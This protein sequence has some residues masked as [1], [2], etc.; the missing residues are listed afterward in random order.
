MAPPDWPEDDP[1]D[2]ECEPGDESL[3]RFAGRF[4]A[5]RPELPPEALE[6]VRRCLSAEIVR[7]ERRRRVRLAVVC[8]GLAAGLL[9]AIGGLFHGMQGRR[10]AP[11]QPI[12]AQSPASSTDIEDR[13]RVAIEWPAAVGVPAAPLVPLNEYRTLIGEI[14]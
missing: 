7:Q 12:I 13:Y 6:R 3:H 11:R 9:I 8:G 5:A 14:Q 2:A 4:D 10:P 1:L